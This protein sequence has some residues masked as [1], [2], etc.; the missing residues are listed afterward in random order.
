VAGEAAEAVVGEAADARPEAREASACPQLSR[1]I[2]ATNFS[3]PT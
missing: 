1:M 2:A 3:P